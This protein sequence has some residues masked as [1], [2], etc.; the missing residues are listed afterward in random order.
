M[1]LRFQ[2]VRRGKASASDAAL[3][4]QRMLQIVK[5]RGYQ[6]PMWFTPAEFAASL[7]KTEFGRTV[8]EFTAAYNELRF[9][10]R[11]EAA[12]RMSE[13]LGELEKA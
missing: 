9:G 4:Y 12:G 1:R 6:K 3:L 13:L 10:R 7:P 2:R 5:R 8:T 11:D